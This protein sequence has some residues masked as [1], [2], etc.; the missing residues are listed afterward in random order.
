KW[1]LYT[2]YSRLQVAW[3]ELGLDEA[4]WEKPPSPL[5]GLEEY[6][7]WL[8]LLRIWKLSN[9]VSLSTHM[10]LRPR[11]RSLLS[12][13]RQFKEVKEQPEYLRGGS[14]YDYQLE[15]ANWLYYQWWQGKPAILGDDPG[16]GKTIQTIAYLSIVYHLTLPKGVDAEQAAK[17]NE[18]TFPFLIV[19]PTTLIDNWVSE[20]RKWAPFL[21]VATLS[22]SA[23]SRDIQLETTVMRNNDLKCH[24]LITSYETISKAPVLSK[25]GSLKINWEAIIYD[26]GH[27]LKN[28]QTKTYKALAKLKSRQRVILT[29]TPLQNDIRELFNVIGFVD[30]TA[31]AEMQDLESSFDVSE[32]Q[33]VENVRKKLRQYML[34]RSK[35]DVELLIPPKHELILPVSMSSLQQNLYKATLTKNVRLLESI[36]SV[37]H[38]SS[39]KAK[40][41]NCSDSE[42]STSSTPLASGVGLREKTAG[43]KVA[44][45]ASAAKP[46][47]ARIG[48]LQNILMEVRRII[49]HPYSI[50]GVEPEFDTEEETQRNLIS[51][52]GKLQLLHELIP[53]LRARGHR[54]LIFSQF[55]DTLA[56]L[57]RYLEAQRVG[58]VYIDGETPPA[59]RQVQ[60]DSFNSP[61]SRALVFLS[62]TR[63]GG[64][65]LN[66][67]TA[68]VVIIYDCD[69]NPHADMQAMARA[70][71]IGQRKPVLVFK[72]VTENSVEERIV[73]AAT[74]KLALDH[75]LIQ[76][77]GDGSG[78]G[79]SKSDEGPKESAIMQ[80]LKKDA[81]SL[82][83]DKSSDVA[84]N[85][86]TI[87]YDHALVSKLLDQCMDALKEADAQ[88]KRACQE[89]KGSGAV[90]D[91]AALSF[92]R[93]WELDSGGNMRS[94]S[95]KASDSASDSDSSEQ[96]A[97]VWSQL[98]K[99][100]EEQMA[101]AASAS[102]NGED[103][104][105]DGGRLRVRKRKINYVDSADAEVGKSKDSRAK[106]VEDGEFVSLS[107]GEDE[108][109][110]ADE[111]GIGSLRSLRTK[112]AN[113]ACHIIRRPASAS[114]SANTLPPAPRAVKSVSG[115]GSLVA[116]RNRNVIVYSAELPIMA[117]IH[118]NS[119]IDGLHS[120]KRAQNIPCVSEAVQQ[121]VI[122]YFGDL[123][124]KF[125]GLDITGIRDVISP[126]LFF[127]VPINFELAQAEHLPPQPYTGPCMICSNAH[128]ASFCPVV[129]TRSFA[130]AI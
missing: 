37:L 60:V 20:F 109:E 127:P 21:S 54:I 86:K 104:S 5:D 58:Y 30:P 42:G 130:D 61:D 51:S 73:K 81:V 56:C 4:T 57:E 11:L 68:D 28:D 95:E 124:R 107:D 79:A 19:V 72:L 89:K 63:T 103:G 90:E 27:R 98:L 122:S 22:G 106:D 129:I 74:R 84:A 87:K 59:K 100:S 50:A 92:A 49:S 47:P 75:L 2:D 65:G 117:A 36:S 38:Q 69:F 55:K 10:R 121:Q 66:L 9:A 44:G 120:F 119:I 118:S 111:T 8:E 31:R 53:E 78:E 126:M 128:G 108:D 1:E 45:G 105:G 46:K 24:V 40:N 3:S 35:S 123:K 101:A 70:H 25:L 85:A 93:V 71:R 7:R 76:R 32:S 125:S 99:I 116:Y 52:C 18:G 33:S 77:M 13:I 14:M 6:E 17:T 88:K 97:D 110:K 83:S 15:G 113:D 102:A 23:K 94:I 16:L 80:A 43:G 29:G 34:R 96:D 12:S 112:A 39:R 41:G 114:A 82:L 64:L 62:T 26:E 48:S 67:T 115:A 91:S